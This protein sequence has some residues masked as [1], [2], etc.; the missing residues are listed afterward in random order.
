[1]SV[2]GGEAAGFAVNEGKPFARVLGGAV[3]AEE[4]EGAGFTGVGGDGIEDEPTG[5][6]A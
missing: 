4:G 1:M 5:F 6:D 3:F 2:G